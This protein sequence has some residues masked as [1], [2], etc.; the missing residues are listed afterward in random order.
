MKKKFF[1]CVLLII[2]TGVLTTSSGCI[3]PMCKKPRKPL[4]TS[5]VAG[6]VYQFNRPM[7]NWKVQLVDESGRVVATEPTNSQG[8]YI[9]SNIP[10]GEYKVHVLTFAGTPFAGFECN[11][12]VR[13]GRMEKLDIDLGGDDTPPPVE[14]TPDDQ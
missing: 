3:N 6:T 11:I 9:I 5:S 10:A 2:I 1:T 8:H 7:P 12:R 13:P 4:I 14:V